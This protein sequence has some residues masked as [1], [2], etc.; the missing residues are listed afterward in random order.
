[1]GMAVREMREMIVVGAKDLSL[2]RA[3]LI[4]M[5]EREKGRIAGMEIEASALYNGLHVGEERNT[6]RQLVYILVS[7]NTGYRRKD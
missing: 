5:E 3:T 7:Q 4:T 2:P 1:M 6:T